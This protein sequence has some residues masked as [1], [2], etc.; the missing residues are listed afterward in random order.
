MAIYF[1][2]LAVVIFLAIRFHF[3]WILWLFPP[4]VPLL[5]IWFFIVMTVAGVMGWHGAMP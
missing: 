5:Y 2:L 3:P 4:A 1:A